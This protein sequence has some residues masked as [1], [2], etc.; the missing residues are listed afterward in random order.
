MGCALSMTKSDY[1]AQRTTRSGNLR[2]V[3]R[4]RAT[5]RSRMPQ[6]QAF[7]A[8]LR[9][10]R[11][12]RSREQISRKLAHLGVPLGGS[13][14]AQ[15]ESGT[16]WAPD[17][18]VLWGLAEI[19]GVEL[20]AVISLLR[21]NRANQVLCNSGQNGDV[22]A[23]Q[24]RTLQPAVSPASEPA[25]PS[26]LDP[27]GDAN[28]TT[29]AQILAVLNDASTALM[30]I[31]SRLQPYLGRQDPTPGHAPAGLSRRAGNDGR[32]DAGKTGR[33]GRRRA[34]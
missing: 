12:E 23:V 32:R 10:W 7:G 15:Y 22:T 17:A 30:E 29:A 8:Q 27:I 2:V 28:A 33:S 6:L 25:T 13:T 19:Y 31:S 11:G 16:V 21:A 3:S 1:Y 34:S 14:L 26:T 24:N 18:G 9:A 4:K 5:A 20:H